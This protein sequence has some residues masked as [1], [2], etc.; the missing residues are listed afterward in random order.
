MGPV[1]SF[2]IWLVVAALVIW[3]VARMNL[4]LEVRGFG[5]AMIAALVISFISAI[6][7]WLLSLFG[8]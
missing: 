1:I 7:V 5:A 2:I 3:L 4:G 6:V 8:L